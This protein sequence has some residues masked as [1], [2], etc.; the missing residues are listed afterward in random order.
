MYATAEFGFGTTE[1]GWLMFGNSLIRG[2][3]LLIFFPK[4]ISRGRQWFQNHSGDSNKRELG[5][6]NCHPTNPEGL[7]TAHGEAVD[8]E[9]I[10]PVDVDVEE[11]D[12]GT[13]FDLFFVQW[14]LFMDSIVT[15]VAGFSRQGWQAYA[16]RLASAQ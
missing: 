8:Q 14:S 7:I 5:N 16:G 2:I 13:E 15:A 1:N 11:E 10:S 6:E 3:F 12:S 4:I 9:P